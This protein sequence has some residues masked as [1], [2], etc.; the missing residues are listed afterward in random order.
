MNPNANGDEDF[1]IDPPVMESVDFNS[2]KEQFS[3]ENLLSVSPSYSLDSQ[4][5][6]ATIQCLLETVEKQEGNIKELA[7]AV[8][9]LSSKK[10]NTEVYRDDQVLDRQS[11][12]S[13]PSIKQVQHQETIPTDS[14]RVS[15]LSNSPF[16]YSPSPQTFVTSRRDS[17]MVSPSPTFTFKEEEA[18]KQKFHH[19]HNEIV[20]LQE[21]YQNH[22]TRLT[23]V[24]AIVHEQLT[25]EKMKTEQKIDEAKEMINILKFD[26]EELLQQIAQLNEHC[27]MAIENQRVLM[28]DG[29][30]KVTEQ[31]TNKFNEMKEDYM[32]QIETVNQFILEKVDGVEKKISQGFEN[33]KDRLDSQRNDIEELKFRFSKHEELVMN[34]FE[35]GNEKVEKNLRALE[36]DILKTNFIS[37]LL[38]D[39]LHLD[40]N[41]I[42]SLP[43][44]YIQEKFQLKE[45][46]GKYSKMK[47]DKS[48]TETKKAFID[49]FLATPA[50]KHLS[51]K[52]VELV[53][54]LKWDSRSRMDR[55]SLKFSDELNEIKDNMRR[56]V[57]YADVKTSIAENES[58]KHVKMLTE[59]HEGNL[60]TIFK[61]F[62]PREEAWDALRKKADEKIWNLK[63]IERLLMDFLTTLMKNLTL[64]LGNQLLKI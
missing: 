35:N 55:D 5:L 32:S 12:V 13:T 28:E 14:E 3:K 51:D 54:E 56:F 41:H 52:T 30:K 10:K 21:E 8:S 23:E 57:T 59:K 44:T 7:R 4:K 1:I 38:Y 50:L 2:L 36:K 27:T 31:Y 60:D 6:V 45:D 17:F 9:R 16:A 43:D 15:P 39:V 19:F 11:V 20:V 49:L 37:N 33:V 63:R 24:E 62:M 64:F 47:K 53:N 40:K 48:R 18:F 29:I 61:T 26:K 34:K 42:T 58:L 25:E 46:I 22:Q